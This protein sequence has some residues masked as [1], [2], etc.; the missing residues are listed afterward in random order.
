M[1]IVGSNR[2]PLSS[3]RWFGPNLSWVIGSSVSQMKNGQELTNCESHGWSVVCNLEEL[4][5]FL[6]H[7]VVD[8]VV[9]AVPLRSFHDLP[10]RLLPCANSR[11]SFFAF[12]PICL[13]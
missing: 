1:L 7:N 9:L 13:I 12:C 8:E 2:V 5:T 10:P 6:R 3:R 11:A 4:R